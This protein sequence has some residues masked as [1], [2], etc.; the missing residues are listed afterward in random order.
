MQGLIQLVCHLFSW[1]CYAR[2]NGWERTH[3][4]VFGRNPMLLPHKTT[5]RHKDHQQISIMYARIMAR[6]PTHRPSFVNQ[7]AGQ[8]R[9]FFASLSIHHRPL[10]KT[11]ISVQTCKCGK[12]VNETFN[13][14]CSI[15]VLMCFHNL[16]T[17]QISETTR[18]DWS[19]FRSVLTN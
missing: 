19:S 7:Y 16:V 5:Y 17:I 14:K 10:P 4:N 8:G 12:V 3:R 15:L 18:P 9:Q 6:R 2:W 13:I 1:S 11:F